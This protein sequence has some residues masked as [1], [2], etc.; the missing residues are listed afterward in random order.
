MTP[1]LKG[2]KV[3]TFSKFFL[4][5]RWEHFIFHSYGEFYWAFTEI[6]VNETPLKPWLVT[7]MWLLSNASSTQI[8]AE[9]P[10]NQGL[11]FASP[12]H[13]CS[14][15]PC[16]T[17][18]GQARDTALGDP[19]FPSYRKQQKETIE[20]AILSALVQKGKKTFMA[21]KPFHATPSRT[22]HLP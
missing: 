2:S 17:V 3:Q 13:P 5:F 10:W 22:A 19:F 21:V 1:V 20:G 14:P 9:A 8:K 6:A 11:P 7:L 15:K 4:G 18:L 12:Q 16:W